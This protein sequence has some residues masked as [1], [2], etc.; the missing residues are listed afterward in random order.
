MAKTPRS[1][2]Q[3][4]EDTD[5]DSDPRV[6]LLLHRLSEIAIL[7]LALGDRGVR[8]VR[9]LLLKRFAIQ[10]GR[11]DEQREDVGD[12]TDAPIGRQLADLVRC[13]AAR[14]PA[15]RRVQETLLHVM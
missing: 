10:P 4:C 12:D 11:G 9:Q 15:Q 13:P 6:L 14:P 8:D 2:P 1:D 5:T 7:V 3:E